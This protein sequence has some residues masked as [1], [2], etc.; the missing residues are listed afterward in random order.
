MKKRPLSVTIIGCLFLATG[1]IGLAYHLTEL[2][3]QH[4]FQSDLVWV[5]IVQLIAIACGV[6][7]LRGSEW[8][9]WLALVW[10]A[11]HVILSVFHSVF[12]LVV[13]GLL[14]VALT[15]FLMRRPA[16][17]YFRPSKREAI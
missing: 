17:E 1:V 8:A 13:H 10:M 5:W 7:I 4:P 2:N 6:Y 3:S 16:T 15:Y 14:F 11:F 12:E 9:R